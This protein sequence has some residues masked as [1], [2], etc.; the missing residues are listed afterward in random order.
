M[1][2]DFLLKKKKYKNLKKQDINHLFIKTI[3]QNDISYG[4]FKDFPRKLV[5]C[6]RDEA[7]YNLE[8]IKHD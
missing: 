6:I 7:F 2:A 1:L 3:F 4:N 8:N 5:I